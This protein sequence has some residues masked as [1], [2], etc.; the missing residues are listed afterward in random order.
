ML[1]LLVIC[2]TGSILVFKSEINT[3]LMPEQHVV[4][5]QGERQSYDQLAKNMSEAFPDYHLGAW[6]IFGNIE[7]QEVIE[8]DRVYLIKNNSFD[9]YKMHLNPFT[10]EILS[11]PVP[12]EDHYFL[13]WLVVLHYTLLLKDTQLLPATTGVWLGLVYALCLLFLG[14][15]GLVIYRKFWR[16]LFTV[17]WRSQLMVVFSDTH[18]CVGV[19][20]SP[21]LLILG[22]TGGY[23]NVVELNHELTEPDSH[24]EFV[25]DRPLYNSELSLDAQVA[26]SLASIDGLKISYMTFPYE[27]ELPF[28][29]YGKVPDTNILTSQY[30]SY[31]AF[32]KNSGAALA[33][34]DAREAGIGYLILDS[35]RHLHFGNF[36][37]LPIKI[38]WALFG[39]APL[40]LAITGFWLWYKRRCQRKIKLNK[41]S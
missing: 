8:A 1:P 5:N 20:A 3:W 37:G 17:R 12:F 41:A 6:E 2:I 4:M 21:L 38:I 27:P 23:F 24:H 19:L 16:K 30:A 18:K 15:S 14:I 28:V 31:S 33:S 26:S 13:D 39:I 35:F 40:L 29:W 10:G 32:D 7:Q 11:T 36:A 34:V 9:W 25:I 22:F